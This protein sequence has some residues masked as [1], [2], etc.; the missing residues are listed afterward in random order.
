MIF[1]LS[2]L[3][4]P[5]NPKCR[6]QLY[7]LDFEREA[8]SRKAPHFPGCPNASGSPAAD[9]PM[10]AFFRK[11]L[12]ISFEI[13]GQFLR[14]RLAALCYLRL[15]PHST[16]RNEKNQQEETG[17]TEKPDSELGLCYLRYL[18]SRNPTPALSAIA[19]H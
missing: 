6:K 1:S 3:I 8:A 15:I 17:I 7:G 18:L 2:S 16:I 11:P 14:L 19:P 10:A 9:G 13:R 5:G 12:R 4:V